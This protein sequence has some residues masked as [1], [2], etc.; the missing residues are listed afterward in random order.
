MVYYGISQM[1]YGI[2]EIDKFVYNLN[3]SIFKNKNHQGSTAILDL[4]NSS[5]RRQWQL[6]IHTDYICIVFGFQMFLSFEKLH[7]NVKGPT[8]LVSVIYV[9]QTNLFRVKLLT[10]RPSENI[11]IIELKCCL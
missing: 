7:L 6:S 9:T 11:K 10:C 4:L 8:S 5:E 3:L 2:C 1:N